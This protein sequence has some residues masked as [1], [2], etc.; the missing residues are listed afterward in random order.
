MV[1]I[2]AETLAMVEGD[3]AARLAAMRPPVGHV[4]VPAELLDRIRAWLDAGLE[5]EPSWGEASQLY[6]ELVR[7]SP[8][9]QSKQP[10]R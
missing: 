7:Y 5:G 10:T 6:N 8:V 3:H 2:P 4:A 9:P 1:M